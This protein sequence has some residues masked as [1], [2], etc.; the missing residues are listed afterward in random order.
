MITLKAM[1]E[2]MSMVEKNQTWE[3]VNLLE[4]RKLTTSSGFTRLNTT[5]TAPSRN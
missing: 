4:E 2:E 5:K 3:M 1:D